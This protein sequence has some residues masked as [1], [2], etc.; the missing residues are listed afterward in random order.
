MSAPAIRRLRRARFEFR[1]REDAAAIAEYVSTLVPA[2]IP[3]EFV[4]TELMLN[5]IEHGNLEIK[6]DKVELVRRGELE[7]E[8][9]RRL[10]DPRFA[11]RVAWLEIE[12]TECGVTFTIGDQG[13]GFAWAEV[14]A[15]DLAEPS[16][17]GLA[18]ARLMSSSGLA[19]NP[20]GNTVTVSMRW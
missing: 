1:T 5:A 18:L 12:R 8:V 3:I 15:P 10:R 7:S 19:F 11:N 13:P 20:E 16:G 4:V 14:T 9:K 6:G 2:R 17:R